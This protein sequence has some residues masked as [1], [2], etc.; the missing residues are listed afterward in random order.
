MHTTCMKTCR[1]AWSPCLEES[2]ETKSSSKSALS[3]EL[4]KGFRWRHFVFFTEAM[5]L[6]EEE[7]ELESLSVATHIFFFVGVF[8]FL[9]WL[10]NR[11]RS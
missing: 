10:C 9:K 2:L 8:A 6:L 11:G 7:L 1:L 5:H 3:E 4:S